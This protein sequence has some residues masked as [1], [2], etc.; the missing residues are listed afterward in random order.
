MLLKK[1]ISRLT[2]TLAVCCLFILLISWSPD[3]AKEKNNTTNY[4]QKNKSAEVQT[5]QKAITLPTEVQIQKDALEALFRLSASEK[6]EVKWFNHINTGEKLLRSII[7]LDKPIQLSNSI[8]IPLPTSITNNL[9]LFDEC[10]IKGVDLNKLKVRVK[11][12]KKLELKHKI[13][14]KKYHSSRI[15][16]LKILYNEKYVLEIHGSGSIDS[17]IFYSKNGISPNFDDRAWSILGA[18]SPILDI[19]ATV[20]PHINRNIEGITKLEQDKFKRI[21]S[22]IDGPKIHLQALGELKK[23]G[24]LP[25]RQMTKLAPLLEKGFGIKNTPKLVEDPSRPGWSDPSF[26]EK[27]YFPDEN[28]ISFLNENYPKNFEFVQCLNNWPSWMEP[29][30]IKSKNEKGTPA[31]E[32]FDS[33]AAL[34]AE[35]IEATKRKN[36]LIANYW[37]VKNESTIKSEW[38][39]HWEKGYDS[40][41]L[42]ADFHNK[43]SRAIKKRLPNI[44]VGGPASAWMHLEAGGKDGFKLAEEQLRFMDLTK[45]YLDFYS[46]HFY[47]VKELIINDPNRVNNYG[48]YLAGRLEAD[49]DLLRNHMLLTDNLK[50]LIISETGTLM[51][52][53]ND[54]DHWIKLKNYN[55]L[56]IRYMNRAHEFKMVIPF[57]IPVNWWEKGAQDTIYDINEDKTLSPT[58]QALFLDFWKNYKG[59]LISLNSTN[60]NIFMHAVKDGQVIYIAVNNMNPQ[61]VKLRLNLPTETAEIIK[62][63]QKR[64]WLSKDEIKYD[65]HI[66]KDLS[67]IPLS[68]E[69]TSI[70]KIT[71]DRDSKFIS[72]QK[73]QTFFGDKVLQDTGQ[74]SAFKISCPAEDIQAAKLRVC[75]GR[76]DGFQKNLSLTFNGELYTSSLKRTNKSGNFFGYEEFIIPPNIIK[77][78]NEVKVYIPQYGGK[79]SSVALTCKIAEDLL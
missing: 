25:G 39:Y 50:P 53:Q 60:H 77:S 70:I 52:A 71:L 37:E 55:S 40:W 11:G 54:I 31:V 4:T 48:G 6:Y 67:K 76:K 41:K 66:L 36:G 10:N 2:N 61:R 15:K 56:M 79:I 27:N 59:D 57:L 65:T 47:E 19:K 8:Q 58:K 69:E 63:E 75:F 29:Q 49:L 3:K 45:D 18:N 5:L 23:S 46:H 32:L 12:P 24:F 17:I 44:K 43:T 20:Y 35:Y 38:L 33:A 30:N 62:I 21:Y 73:E 74:N 13:S 9:N 78:K 22:N 26:F 28:K 1:Y 16:D 42:L 14:N 64:M 51:R 7:F 72:S 68:V 34:A